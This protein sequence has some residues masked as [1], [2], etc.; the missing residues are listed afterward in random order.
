MSRVLQ[1]RRG[2]TAQNDNFTGLAGEITYDTDAK[3]IRVHDG[4]TLGG[5]ALARADEIPDPS[6]EFDIDSVPDTKWTEIVARVAPAPF[7]TY[8][9]SNLTIS[10]STY[11]EYV[12][13][14]VSSAPII[15]RASLVCQT[16]AAGYVT[17][18]ETTAFGIGD[19][20]TPPLYTF[21]DNN[22]VHVRVMIGGG[23]F[24]V[25]HKTTGVKTNIVNSE[26]KLKIRIYC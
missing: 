26:W 7:A 23:A 8:T 14:G 3:T 6:T 20:T 2:T 1:I 25:A 24:W 21:V 4:Q 9:S 19:Y 12:F 17:N 10:G 11:I 16:D 22:G 5:V 18:D 13:S 15:A